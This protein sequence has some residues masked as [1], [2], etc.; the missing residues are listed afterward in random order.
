MGL[1][2][3]PKNVRKIPQT[4]VLV[5]S[6]KAAEQLIWQNNNCD[7]IVQFPAL[8]TDKKFLK[9]LKLKSQRLDS[10]KKIIRYGFS[11]NITHTQCVPE[12]GALMNQSVS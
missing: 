3:W 12:F 5:K 9:N 1:Q 6:R 10:N 11:F 7:N 2:L 8:F 4:M